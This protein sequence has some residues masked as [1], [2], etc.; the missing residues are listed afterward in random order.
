[1]RG[2]YDDLVSDLKSE[3]EQGQIKITRMADRLS[4]SL[5]DKILFASGEVEI[6]ANG[7]KVLRRVGE[8]LKNT[9]GKTIRVEGHTDN[10]PI[11]SRLADQFPTNWEFSNSRASNV[12]RFLQGKVGIE[13]TR[14]QA[15]GM[16]QY[17]PVASNKTAAG[18]RLRCYLNPQPQRDSQQNRHF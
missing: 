9:E 16:S 5:V 18:P 10:V 6:T 11:S 1:M 8:I 17:H 4:V 14:L 12:V 7:I 2:T 15:V 13:A 3:I